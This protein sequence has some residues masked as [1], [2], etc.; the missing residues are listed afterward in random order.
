MSEPQHSV[1]AT[2][3]AVVEELLAEAERPGSDVPALTHSQRLYLRLVEPI[4][5][6]NGYAFLA[7]PDERGKQVI[8]SELGELI[9]SALSR[10]F[11]RPFSLAVS[12]KND[13][14]DPEHT[15]SAP[16]AAPAAAPTTASA[17]PR[18]DE[19]QDTFASPAP[20]G[21]APAS[22]DELADAHRAQQAQQGSGLLGSRIPRETP[23][24]DPN[25]E[26]SLN[27][28]HTFENFVIGSSNRFANGAAVAVAESPALAYNP[29]FIWGGSG[30]GKTHL[31]HAAGN[32][33]QLLHP[34]LRVKYVSSEEF[35]NDYINSLRDDRQESFKRRYRNL[36][37]LMVDDIQFLEGKE[38]TQ[39]EFFHTFNALHQANKQIILSSDRPPKQLTTL[40]D[41]LRTRFEGGLITDVQPPDLETR[42]AILMKKAESDGTRIDR[43]VLELIASRFEN[44]IREL[45]GALIRVSAYSSLVNQPIDMEMAEIALRDLVPDSA[46][47]QITAAVIIDV[48]ADY[49][50][51]DADD[52]RGAGKKR[53][54]A[55][56]RQLAMYLCRELTEMSLPKI[57]EQ[58]GGKDHT[59]VM[60][61][62]R[63]IR[64][65]MNENRE[66]YT[67]IQ[68]L[69]SKIQTAARS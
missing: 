7:A 38:S 53:T 50:S 17:P 14:P 20:S 9:T 29:L 34:G 46:G 41:R 52:L 45:E 30:L 51:I 44:S 2:W 62:D 67:E 43:D 59:T 32:Y 10:L 23:A 65:E 26:T 58:F 21:M 63:K 6:D 13:A 15:P 35:T 12:V 16:A 48:T 28:K 4:M 27:P 1:T 33:A 54:I 18:Q 69:T 68:E 40:E 39:E 5:V 19:W 64:K 8:E 3:R 55:H 60:Y 37:I 36:D 47:R 49:F 31:L 25:R 57:G 61:A 24:H 11:S 22:L 56:A 42:I 66:T